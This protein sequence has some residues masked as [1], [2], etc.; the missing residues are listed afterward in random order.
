[1]QRNRGKIKLKSNA[2]QNEMG[3][4]ATANVIQEEHKIV[5]DVVVSFSPLALFRRHR[6]RVFVVFNAVAP[7]KSIWIAY[8]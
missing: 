4:L 7:L 8:Y 5:V 6:I 3:H 1:M 2:E